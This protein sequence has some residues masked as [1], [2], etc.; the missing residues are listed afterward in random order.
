[1][2]YAF[3]A[4]NKQGLRAL[5]LDAGKHHAI[6]VQVLNEKEMMTENHFPDYYSFTASNLLATIKLLMI[7]WNGV[8]G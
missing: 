7:P 1:M 2:A 4:L 8:G 6:Y 5:G 3:L